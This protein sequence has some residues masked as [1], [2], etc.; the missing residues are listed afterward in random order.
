MFP[1]AD[2]NHSHGRQAAEGN[3]DL[4]T[5]K[6]TRARSLD[7]LGTR[8]DGCSCLDLSIVTRTA[9][10]TRTGDVNRNATA[11]ELLL[12]HTSNGR[13]GLFWCGEGNKPEPLGT[14]GLTIGDDYRFDDFAELG[15]SV[16]QTIAGSTPTDAA[17][18]E[19]GAFCGLIHFAHQSFYYL[20]SGEQGDL[21]SQTRTLVPITHV[22][23][24]A[25][26][27]LNQEPVGYKPTALTD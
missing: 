8:T 21:S 6:N 12:I 26:L 11:V 15:K 22:Y 7:K 20:S 14:T 2:L 24:W 27:D 5:Q 25:R 1:G 4:L 17:H 10:F 23:W 9:V 3:I 13:F 19:L 16:A 18:E